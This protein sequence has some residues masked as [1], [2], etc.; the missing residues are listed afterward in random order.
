MR[1]LLSR[2]V[3]RPSMV[4]LRRGGGGEYHPPTPEQMRG[5]TNNWF[6]MHSHSV[7]GW[8]PAESN[9]TYETELARISKELGW[10]ANA[11]LPA[12]ELCDEERR[13]WQWNDQMYMMFFGF[14][15][16]IF[17]FMPDYSGYG[18]QWSRR[19]AILRINEAVRDGKSPIDPDYAP[20]ELIEQMVPP[21]GDWEK[22][23]LS[24]QPS[25]IARGVS[26]WC[27]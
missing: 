24:R 19:E 7:I 2:G 21:P 1:R 3:S 15:L 13:Y 27:W 22:I 10:D 14:W 4:S 8:F 25:T 17:P 18:T 23:W 6:Y 11:H 12:P 5:A 9:T 26:K 20:A 16:G